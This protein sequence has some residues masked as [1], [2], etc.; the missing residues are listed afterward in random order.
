MGD[1]P[2][3]KSELSPGVWLEWAE[4]PAGPFWM[5]A[6]PEDKM[7]F[8]DEKPY[9]QVNLEGFRLGKYPVTNQQFELF[10]K[11][12]GYEVH[13]HCQ[14]ELVDKTKSDCPVRWVYWSNVVAFCEWASQKTGEKI[15]L[16]TEAEWEKG[17]RGTDGRVYPWGMSWEEGRCNSTRTG[18]RATTP[19]TRYSGG[20]SPYGVWDMA[21]NVWEWTNS[22]FMPYP[23][24][25]IAD[26]IYGQKYRVLRGGSWVGRVELLRS[27]FRM[28]D[29]SEDR[30]MFIGF[31]CASTLG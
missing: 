2:S 5:G 15:Y 13:S 16:P 27:S 4:V 10:V 1:K 3:L 22:W 14:K 31:R 29:D 9:H 25:K 28:K 8:G 24:H 18:I 23:N 11:D 6:H 7:A 26:N 19:V 17:A 21:G 30:Y 20:V 12:T